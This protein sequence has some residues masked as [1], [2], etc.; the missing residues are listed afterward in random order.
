MFRAGFHIIVENQ[1]LKSLIANPRVMNLM[2]A[3]HM[4]LMMLY[5]LTKDA[6]YF[7]HREIV[8]QAG[9]TKTEH[10]LQYLLA[11]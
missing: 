10:W 2:I 6:I 1:G 11:I 8:H 3:L 7:L 9:K 4:L 5:M